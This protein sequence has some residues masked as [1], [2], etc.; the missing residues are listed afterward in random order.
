MPE[1]VV[2]LTV[3]DLT[4]EDLPTLGE[5]PSKLTSM[6]TE[7]GR[8]ERGEVDYLAVCT[9]SG[10]AVGYGAVDYTKPPGGATI[11]QLTVLT[12]FQSCGIGTILIYA[13]EDHIRARGIP[14][15]ELGID[16]ASPRPQALYERLGYV[17]S[18]TE[19]GSWDIDTPDGPARYETTITLLRKQLLQPPAVDSL[20][21][22]LPRDIVRRLESPRSLAELADGLHITDARVLWY[23]T[24]LAAAGLVKQSDGLWLR[25]SLGADYLGTPPSATDDVTVLPGR[26]TYDYQQAFADSRAGMFGSTYVQASGEHG[27]RVPYARAVEFNQRLQDLVAEYFAPNR[28][29]RSASPKYGFHWVLTPTDLHPLDDE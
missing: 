22:A 11:Y 10:Q 7:L 2:P 19:L 13:L 23:L 4:L 5:S 15:A 17:V 28:I 29:D 16:D 6:V 8:A 20:D 1:I 3:R 24:K 21:S 12:P 9:P 25:T 27:G 14:F 26:T 18:G